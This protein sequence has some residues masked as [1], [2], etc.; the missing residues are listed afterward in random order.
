MICYKRGVISGLVAGFKVNEQLAA[1]VTRFL[2]VCLKDHV[3]SHLHAKK[4]QSLVWLSSSPFNSAFSPDHPYVL[5]LVRQE[6]EAWNNKLNCR[7]ATIRL[8]TIKLYHFHWIRVCFICGFP[9]WF[10]WTQSSMFPFH[11]RPFSVLQ[12]SADRCKWRLPIKH[13]LL[14]NRVHHMPKLL[15][16]NLEIYTWSH[17]LPKAKNELWALSGVG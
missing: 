12:D 14:R 16:V 15:A 5:Q 3:W 8:Q 4:S 11:P 1:H 17:R 9:L 13:M 7:Y 2:I 10:L 6:M